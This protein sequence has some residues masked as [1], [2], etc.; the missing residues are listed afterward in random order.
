MVGVSSNTVAFILA[1]YGMP[2]DNK[3]VRE[4]MNWALSEETT[5]KLSSFNLVPHPLPMSKY[6]HK[7]TLGKGRA[8]REAFADLKSHLAWTDQDIVIYMDGN[9][10]EFN[11]SFRIIEFIKNKKQTF[12]ASS[13]HNGLGISEERGIIEKFE[14]YILSQRYGLPHLPDVQCGFWGFKANYLKELTDVLES[15]TFEIELEIMNYFLRKRVLPAYVGVD[16]GKPENTTFSENHSLPKILKL[17][18]WLKFNRSA[19]L[20]LADKFQKKYQVSLPARYVG[21]FSNTGV[22]EGESPKTNSLWPG[23]EKSICDC[24]QSCADQSHSFHP[25]HTAFK[26]QDYKDEF[27]DSF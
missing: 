13:R 25:C 12:V 21:L 15:E 16:I 24:K 3:R 17:S 23:W 2:N 7:S 10:I 6:T 22:Y 4:F 9:Q 20:T 27:K 19:L 11:D 8:I 14:N 5:K 18:S 26:E 1:V